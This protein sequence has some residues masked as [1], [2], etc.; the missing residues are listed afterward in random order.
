MWYKRHRADRLTVWVL[1]E[2]LSVDTSRTDQSRIQGFNLVGGH[3]DLDVT[4][5]IESIKLV[6]KL[7]HG[8]LDFS[9]T[10]RRR[11]ITLRTNRID[12]VNENNGGGVL[13]CNLEDLTDQTRAISKVLLNQ[14]T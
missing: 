11:I 9:F 2:N 6:K 5:I 13:S 7:K 3:D 8:T 12:F 10:T 1:E 14:L 4:A